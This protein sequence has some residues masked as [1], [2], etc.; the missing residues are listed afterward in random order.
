V[1]ALDDTSHVAVVACMHKLI[2]ILNA[3]LNQGTGWR[4]RS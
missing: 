4:Q 1:Q 3:M 2:M